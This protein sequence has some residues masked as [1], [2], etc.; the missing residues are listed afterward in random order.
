MGDEYSMIL[1]QFLVVLRCSFCRFYVN[2]GYGEMLTD[3]QFKYVITKISKIDIIG[4]RL[5]LKFFALLVFK[6]TALIY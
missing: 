4:N 5:A 2:N 1:R 6:T 3:I